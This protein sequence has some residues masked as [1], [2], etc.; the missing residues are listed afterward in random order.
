MTKKDYE[1]IADILANAP[2]VIEIEAPII[3]KQYVND[4]KYFASRLATQD[5]RFKREQFLKDCGVT[6]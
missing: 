4:C 5:K 3:R 2:T 1:L 6:D